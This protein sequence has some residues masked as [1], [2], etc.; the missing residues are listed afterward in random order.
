M[1]ERSLQLLIVG[2][3]PDDAD[4]NAGG[5]AT[6][7]RDRGHAVKMISVTDGSSGHHERWGPEL[8]ERRRA[9]AQASAAVIGATYEVWDYPDGRLEPT[10][11]LR[12]R[13]IRE[14][15]TLKPDLVLTHRPNDYH[16]DHRAVGRA[17]Q[18]TA[19]MVTV[20]AVVPDVPPLRRDPVVAHL[21][22]RF[23]KPTPI[24]PDAVLDIT[25]KLDTIVRMMS[26]HESQVFE[27]LPYNEGRLGEVPS[28]ENERMQWLRRWVERRIRP[29]AERCR[30]ELI[31][32]YGD[33][34]GAAIEFAE[35]FELSEYAG[36]THD[37][38]MR[39]L[40]LFD[41]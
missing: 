33:E 9:E 26:R 10:L 31:E 21:W 15:R 22:D 16:P 24:H 18:D 4:I 41:V 1:A 19:Y 23:T 28:D 29:R 34:R 13:L 30:G 8:A 17:M 2:A 7:Y 36:S 35:V 6:T 39:G 14:I 11:D 38:L 25:D 3:H 12:D 27:W 20:P 40:N 37:D 5:L 32:A